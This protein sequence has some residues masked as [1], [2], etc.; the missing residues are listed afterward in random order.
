MNVLDYLCSDRRI[1][2]HFVLC[3]I[4]GAAERHQ[5]ATPNVNAKNADKDAMLCTYI[6]RLIY[7]EEC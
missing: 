3:E 4:R 6:L 5:K 2:Y 7:S 1:K